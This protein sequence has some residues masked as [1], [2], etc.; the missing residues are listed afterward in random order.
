MTLKKTV[1]IAAAA[2]AM[3]AI[4]VPAMAIENE[5]HGT[6]TFNGI[7]SNFAKGDGSQVNPASY[8]DKKKMNNYFEQRARLQYIAKVSDDLKL[9]TQFELDTRFGGITDNKY[10]NSSDAGGLDADGISLETK[11]VYLD[12]NLGKTN[13]KTGIQPYKDTIKGLFIDADLPAVVTTTKLTDKYTLGLGYARFGETEQGAVTV[14]RLGGNV[15][16]LVILDN[17]FAFSKDTKAAL[18]Y[19]FYA[20][21]TPANSKS[22]YL[23]TLGLSGE[24]KFGS[25]SLSG[26]AA[27][28]AGHNKN[29]NGAGAT[30]NRNTYLH[31]WMAQV[32]AKM[33]VGP[34]TAKTAFLFV[35]GNNNDSSSNQ[36]RGWVT[37]LNSYN[38]SG[39]MILARNTANSPTNTDDYLRRPVNNIALATIGYDAKITDKVYANG[40]VGFSFAPSSAGA[41]VDKRTGVSNSSD[42]MAAEMNLESGYMVNSNLTLRAQAAYAVLGGYYKNSASNGT[43]AAPKDPENPYTMRLLAS[44]K[45]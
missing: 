29:Q 39:M 30:Q 21:T 12:F 45:F 16:D 17:T 23:N 42:F 5:F 1:A 2:G 38:E 44:F 36:S 14:N 35:S 26:A 15:R 37:P 34:G 43:A 25:L 8:P 33:P 9:V 19:Y 6:Y 41:P 22:V 13:V 3:A 7:F 28:Q 10:T 4:A 31:G 40:N 24:T 18:S 20:D 32:G 11:H 27:M